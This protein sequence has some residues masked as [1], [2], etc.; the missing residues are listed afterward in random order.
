[1]TTVHFSRDAFP[2]LSNFYMMDRPIPHDGCTY[3]SSEHLYQALKYGYFANR[4]T[5]AV[6]DLIHDIRRQSTPYKA[7]VLASGPVQGAPRYDWQRALIDR[8]KNYAARGV[9]LDPRW[10][11]VRIDV[12]EDVLRLKF[13]TDAH[14]RDVL[15][16]TGSATLVER[17]D[18]DRFWGDGR[19]RRGRNML[20]V[21]LM[22]IRDEWRVNGVPTTVPIIRLEPLSP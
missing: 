13:F 16:A 1:M 3:A 14:C 17:T 18:T 11:D 5:P 15:L 8:A 12:M 6:R 21:L 19:D 20:G 10:N 7:K 22:R 9:A 2:E 4:D